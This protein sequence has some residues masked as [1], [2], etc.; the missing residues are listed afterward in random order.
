MTFVTIIRVMRNMGK[1]MNRVVVIFL[2]VGEIRFWWRD[3]QLG[4]LFMDVVNVTNYM[5]N[6]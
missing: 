4:V 1:R 6:P 2:R 5:H 3:G